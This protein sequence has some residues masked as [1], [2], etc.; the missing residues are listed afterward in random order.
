MVD[1]EFQLTTKTLNENSALQDNDLRP[2]GQPRVLIS[3]QSSG[4]SFPGIMWSLIRNLGNGFTWIVACS[5]KHQSLSIQL[6][7]LLFWK[8][9]VVKFAGEASSWLIELA[10]PWFTLRSVCWRGF[11]EVT[12]C[13]VC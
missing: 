7:P 12:P 13:P 2:F 9:F 5:T 3:S 10:L 8:L 11:T 1:M 6:S 4:L